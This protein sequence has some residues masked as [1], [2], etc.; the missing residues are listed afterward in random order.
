MSCIPRQDT[1]HPDLL[2]LINGY[3]RTAFNNNYQTTIINDM[4]SDGLSGLE[5]MT[6]DDIK[7]ACCR[8]CK[9]SVSLFSIIL[10]PIEKER[11]T[12]ILLWVQSIFHVSLVP[13]FPD[14]VIRYQC[15]GLISNTLV[16]GMNCK[17]QKKVGESWYNAEFNTKLKSQGNFD[18]FEEEIQSTLS[19]IIE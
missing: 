7:C 15:I 9:I 13:V 3:I 16:Q 11:I 5:H 10:T 17:S 6:Q 4:L 8:Y 12:S 1:K 14:D 2:A 19:T 18:K